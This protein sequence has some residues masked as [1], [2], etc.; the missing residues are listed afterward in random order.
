M[1][2]NPYEVLGVREGASQEEIKKAYRALVK[3]YHP[4]NYQDHP[5]ADLAKEKMQEINAAY[6]QL[7]SGTYKAGS[8]DSR[9]DQSGY[10]GQGRQQPW[11]QWQNQQRP[12]G[13]P[14][15]PYYR[16]SGDLC[17]TLS[18]L[19]CADSC[20]ECCGSDLISCC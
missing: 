18:C 8:A 13:N 7:T 14:A 12:Y 9:Q 10:A 2:K 17:D 16:Q 5:L 11:Q 4:D 19:C 20:C 1:A 3:K 15:G 6:E